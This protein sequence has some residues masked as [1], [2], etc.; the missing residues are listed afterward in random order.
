M[1]HTN[2]EVFIL[3]Y[4]RKNYLK[5]SINS[6]L[7]QSYKPYRLTIV[8]NGSIDG[9]SDMCQ[10]YQK[11]GVIYVKN[12]E[13]MQF[14]VW[15]QI[16]NLVDSDYF[17]IFH[18]DDLLHTDY[19]KNVYEI[20]NCKN[21]VVMVGCATG[22]S[23]INKINSYT[24]RHEKIQYKEFNTKSLA[25]LLFKG[26][27]L[28]FCSIIYKSEYFKNINFDFNSYGKFFDRPLILNFSKFGN[29]VIIKN[30]LVRTFVHSDQDSKTINK[31]GNEEKL[32][33]VIK[34]YKNILGASFFSKQ[35][36]VFYIF[37]YKRL[38]DFYIWNGEESS[39][40]RFFL[41]S[42]EHSATTKTA[43]LIGFVYYY[44]FD[45]KSKVRFLLNLFSFSTHV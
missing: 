15:E 21:D 44:F 24:F 26:F 10:E 36:I 42:I 34:A 12:T 5:Y 22:V 29:V 2:I 11:N 14:G 18:D 6:I 28:P 3:T 25:S 41:K 31:G 23:N 33:N 39:K 32:I 20:I 7:N 4:N 35:S 13:N 37:N 8:D 19:L 40:Y 45:L 1:Q 16:K 30:K 17:M 38:L 43:L 27:P 9:T